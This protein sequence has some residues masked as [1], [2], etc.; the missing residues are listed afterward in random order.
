MF[1]YAINT[2]YHAN[3][4]KSHCANIEPLHLQLEVSPIDIALGQMAAIQKRLAQML[5]DASSVARGGGG[6]GGARALPILAEKFPILLVW[7]SDFSRKI[8][9]NFGENL[10]FFF[11]DHLFLGG[12]TFE[13]PS[14]PRNSLSIFGQTMWFWFKNNEN[15]GQGRL[16]FSHSFK[17]A[18]QSW[19]R[20]YVLDWYVFFQSLN[21]S[22]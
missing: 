2:Q 5:R 9:L 13:F 20:A 11:G 19:L 1:V 7:I 6:G 12:K 18:P 14:F 17:K 4:L 21:K 22:Q 15:S 8:N 3:T 16:H 10:F